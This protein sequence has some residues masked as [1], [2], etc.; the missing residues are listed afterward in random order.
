MTTSDGP[1]SDPGVADGDPFARTGTADSAPAVVATSA[2]L[3]HIDIDVRC[4]GSLASAVTIA[5]TVIFNPTNTGSYA[6]WILGLD[7][8]G[9]PIRDPQYE[10]VLEAGES[11]PRF[12]APV[13]RTRS[14]YR[15]A[16]VL[17]SEPVAFGSPNRSADGRGRDDRRRDRAVIGATGGQSVRCGRRFARLCGGSWYG[18]R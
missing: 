11:R 1:G 5:S 16:R 18:P 7:A 17:T 3:F 14:P 15:A 6:I 4:P 2:D 12:D 13:A 8:A 9:R 10:L